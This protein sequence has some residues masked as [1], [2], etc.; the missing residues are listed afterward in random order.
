MRK[1]LDM[2][3]KIADAETAANEE[4]EDKDGDKKGEESETRPAVCIGVV[5]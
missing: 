4:E 5:D 1:A 3:R 2:I